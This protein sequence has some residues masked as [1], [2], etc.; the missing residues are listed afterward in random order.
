MSAD[1]NRDGRCPQYLEPFAAMFWRLRIQSYLLALAFVVALVEG[2]LL[3]RAAAYA[4][5][6]VYEIHPDGRAMYVGEREANLAPR[7]IEVERVARDFIEALYGWN[8]STVP[9]DLSDA[10]NLCNESFGNELRSELAEAEFIQNIRNRHERSQVKFDE[11]K[12]IEYSRRHSAVR[13]CGKVYAYSLTD[14]TGSPKKT[15]PFDVQL[16]MQAV[17]RDP[18]Y[19]TNGLEVV[20]MHNLMDSAKNAGGA[21]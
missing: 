13:V 17:T 2:V 14:Y 1:V 20:A 4:S 11:V 15:R 7:R 21:Q 6:H 9:E 3:Y 16:T 8:S 5:A 12:I 18:I 10:V 19:K